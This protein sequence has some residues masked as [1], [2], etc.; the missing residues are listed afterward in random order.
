MVD[1]DAGVTVAVSETVEPTA[2][3]LTDETRTVVVLKGVTEFTV[4][5]TGAEAEPLKFVL[6]A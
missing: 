1:P 6:P 4:T 2:A 3:L 5:A